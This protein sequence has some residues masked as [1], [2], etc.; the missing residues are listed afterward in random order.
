MNNLIEKLKTRL[1][2]ALKPN[3]SLTLLKQ[4]LENCLQDIKDNNSE[5]THEKLSIETSSDELQEVINLINEIINEASNQNN[6]VDNI[7][8]LVQENSNRIDDFVNH[9]SNTIIDMCFTNGDI[10]MNINN[11]KNLNDKI[12]ESSKIIVEKGDF[13][14]ELSN[15]TAERS[16]VGIEKMTENVVAIEK[17]SEVFEELKFEFSELKKYSEDIGEIL[18]TIENIEK[19]TN[20]LSLNAAIEAA[21]AGEHGLGFA[22]V[23]NEINKLSNNTSDSI[24]KISEI[25]NH[26]QDKISKS[27]EMLT[28]AN[29]YM[30]TSVEK[31]E[32]VSSELNDINSYIVELKS[33]VTQFGELA[34]EQFESVELAKVNIDQ[35][36]TI[37]AETT[38]KG[39]E[40]SEF[41]TSN[42]GEISGLKDKIFKKEDEK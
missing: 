17:V 4:S 12:V 3:S 14:V 19:N 1:D 33:I 9:L 35:T 10:E 28:Q 16:H 34:K 41:L 23:A 2:K 6:K 27:S 26:L 21:R 22:V 8:T 36:F 20:L 24:G 39:N 29:E 31:N 18:T 40:T 7:K 37:I 25:T 13:G 32:F 11:I 15:K 42:L 38:T 30:S 5:A